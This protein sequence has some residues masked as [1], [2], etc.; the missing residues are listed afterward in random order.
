MSNH[1]W[2]VTIMPRIPRVV[3]QQLY[4]LTFAFCLGRMATNLF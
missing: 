4:T 3:N 2:N 1:V